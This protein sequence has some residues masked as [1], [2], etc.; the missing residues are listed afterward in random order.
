MILYYSGCNIICGYLLKVWTLE[1]DGTYQ[2]RIRAENRYG[3]SD[4]CESE[5]VDIK[6]PFKLAG[7]PGKPVVAEH[8]KDSMLVTW[9][10]PLDDGGSTIT[11]YWLEK[12]EKGSGYWARVN[13]VPISKRGLKRWEF[14]VPRLIE[15]LQY[16]FRVLACNAAG[17]G[18]PSEP[19]DPALA[20]DPLCK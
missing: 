9:E 6:D 16:E 17:V 20:V 4:G 11:G 7:P 13:R 19:S 10:P 2:F 8:Y 15:G 3:I 1:N 5:V 18:P 12:R 14:C